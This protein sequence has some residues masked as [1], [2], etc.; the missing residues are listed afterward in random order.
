[1]SLYPLPEGD[2]Y[3]GLP[4]KGLITRKYYKTVV[5]TAA[6]QLN[7]NKLKNVTNRMCVKTTINVIK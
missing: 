6:Y 7:T 1:M 3:V 4:L 5:F 2:I